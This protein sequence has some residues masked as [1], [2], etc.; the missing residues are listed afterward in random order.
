MQD[1]PRSTNKASERDAHD[2]GPVP[3]W[4]P[5][6]VHREYVQRGRP[7]TELAEEWGCSVDTITRAARKFGFK[8]E[9]SA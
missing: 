2:Y 4:N 8:P 9:A 5:E 7:A 1:T 3:W 6:A